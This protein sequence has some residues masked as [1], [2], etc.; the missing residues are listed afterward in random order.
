MPRITTEQIK[1]GKSEVEVYDSGAKPE[2]ADTPVFV[3][4]PGLGGNPSSVRLVADKLKPHGRVVSL[5][6]P[7]QGKSTSLGLLQGTNASHAKVVEGVLKKLGIEKNRVILV[8]AS[9]GAQV[10]AEMARRNPEM[11]KLVLL[12]PIYNFTRQDINESPTLQLLL[13][14]PVRRMIGSALYVAYRHLQSRN[15]AKEGRSTWPGAFTIVS[16][17]MNERY[18]PLPNTTHTLIYY[19]G[20]EEMSDI[21]TWNTARRLRLPMNAR[22]PVDTDEH[23]LPF[24]RHFLAKLVPTLMEHGFLPDALIKT[25]PRKGGRVSIIARTR[26]A[27]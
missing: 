25:P 17:H 3:I 6:L 7:G 2:K 19:P 26:A 24:D 20:K 15:V 27:P 1:L 23:Y 21:N 18:K 16:A 5:S 12:D 8:G 14:G 11:D 13:G 10:A 4:I 22:I 9:H